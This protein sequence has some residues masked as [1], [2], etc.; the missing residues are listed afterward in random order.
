MSQPRD[1]KKDQKE[2]PEGSLPTAEDRKNIRDQLDRPRRRGA[3][4]PDTPM[5]PPQEKKNRP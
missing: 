1:D 5:P 3:I 2:N 4:L